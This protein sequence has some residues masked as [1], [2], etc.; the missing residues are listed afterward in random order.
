M[1]AEFARPGAAKCRALVVEPCGQARGPGGRLLRSEEIAGQTV[2]LLRGED[3]VAGEDPED[4][5]AHADGGALREQE[6]RDGSAGPGAR[7][8]GA[9]RRLAIFDVDGTLVDSVVG[10]GRAF[11]QA[12]RES[13]GRVEIDMTWES[14]P[15]ATDSSIAEVLWDQVHRR[16]PTAE[17]IAAAQRRLVALMGEALAVRPEEFR[18]IGGGRGVFSVLRRRGWDVA[19]ATGGWEASARFK[20]EAA[21][22]AVEGVPLA[23]ADHGISRQEILTAARELAVREGRGGFD[24]V[25][26]VGDAAWDLRTCA[27]LG[28]PFV[29]VAQGSRAERLRSL[30]ASHLLPHLDDVDALLGA[31]ENARAP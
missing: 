11:A 22:I 18:P 6:T 8:P 5:R 27:S 16:R 28:W 9:M 14:Y 3:D 12:M 30:G 25:V 7:Y 21:G 26:Y 15:H 2:D 20:L 13:L 17:E 4:P 10:D 29:A 23:S 24:R 31:L 19:I 1:P